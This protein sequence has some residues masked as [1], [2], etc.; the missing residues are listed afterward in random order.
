[1][2]T[3]PGPFIVYMLRDIDIL[4]DW[5]AI[6]K[7]R[8]CVMLYLFFLGGG[9][10]PLFS[11]AAKDITFVCIPVFQAKTAPTPLKK[12]VESECL[13]AHIHSWWRLKIEP[14]SC[15]SQ[16]GDVRSTRRRRVLGGENPE[17]HSS[18]SQPPYC[19]FLFKINS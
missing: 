1:M 16:S 6:K 14:A 2:M 17:K 9:G 8:K 15:V 7:V 4:E 11:L 5:T 10:D 18:A 13:R 19:S 12:K 3:V